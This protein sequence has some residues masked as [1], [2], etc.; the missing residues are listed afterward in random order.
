M[1]FINDHGALVC[2]RQHETLRIEPWGRDALRVRAT[3]Y[4]S[5]SGQDWALTEPVSPTEGGIVFGT[6]PWREG[7]G[8]VSQYP[9]ATI[10]N[11]RVSIRVNHSGVLSVF[12]DGVRI[13]RERYRFYDG[14]ATRESH[15]QKI[16][17]RDWVPYVGGDYKLTVRFEPND[18]EKLF[19]MGTYQHPWLD[20]KGCVL[21]LAQ[22]NS[23]TTVPFA[24]SDL[25]YGFLWNLPAV[26]R[27]SFGKT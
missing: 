11:G 14:T 19:G 13:L 26:G 8:S 1:Q 27:V 2:R 9:V 5:F 16:P 4:P 7:D 12:R 23:Q 17:A 21:E 6:E 25:G 10:T 22:K 3:L 15:C 20:V 24:L 18:G